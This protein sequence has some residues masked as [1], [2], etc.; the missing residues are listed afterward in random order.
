SALA[1]GAAAP[2]DVREA[3]ARLRQD[4]DELM[5]RVQIVPV[6]EGGKLAGVRLSA[7][8]ADADLIGKIGLRP[9]DIVTAV[10]G[11]PIDS[12]ARGRQIVSS[13]QNSSSVQVT[14]L[15]DGKPTELTVGLQ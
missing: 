4:P 11:A 15:R 1:R 13:L 2:A 6:L 9:G 3:A 5:K 12:F 8:G 7:I 10:N 14:V